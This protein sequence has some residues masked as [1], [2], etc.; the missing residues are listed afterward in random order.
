LKRSGWLDHTPEN[1]Y[2]AQL[3]HQ[4]GLRRGALSSFCPATPKRPETDAEAGLIDLPH[5]G[6]T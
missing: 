3:K 6:R 4:N 2:R 1:L 5:I